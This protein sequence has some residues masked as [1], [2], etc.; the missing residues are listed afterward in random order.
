MTSASIASITNLD[1]L[2]FASDYLTLAYVYTDLSLSGLNEVFD[3]KKQFYWN[4][5]TY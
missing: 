1:V 4:Q 2:E 3:V 5:Y